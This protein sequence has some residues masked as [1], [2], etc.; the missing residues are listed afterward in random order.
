MDSDCIVKL[1]DA[2]AEQEKVMSAIVKKMEVKADKLRKAR[3]LELPREI[4]E[5]QASISC[6]KALH[7]AEACAAGVIQMR[8]EEERDKIYFM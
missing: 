8:I 6:L 5:L 2:L 1:Y 7:A 3:K 4:L